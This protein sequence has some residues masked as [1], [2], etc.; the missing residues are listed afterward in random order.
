[1]KRTLLFIYTHTN[2]GLSRSKAK[3]AS[4]ASGLARC[5]KQPLRRLGQHS[6]GLMSSARTLLRIPWM[7]AI[8]QLVFRMAHE[9][10]VLMT[11]SIV[12]LPAAL[13]CAGLGA[14]ARGAAAA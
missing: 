4:N 10:P 11:A 13:A 12:A 9:S 3:L 1:M 7:G 6:M 14:A 2:R 8:S 5:R